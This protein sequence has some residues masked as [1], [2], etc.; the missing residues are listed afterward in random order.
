MAQSST[1]SDI[2]SILGLT[3]TL[4]LMK[5]LEVLQGSHTEQGI[6][7]SIRMVIIGSFPDG[8]YGVRSLESSLNSG[9]LSH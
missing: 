9:S 5:K 4:R 1:G 7:Q 8:G 2:K 6:F 3:G